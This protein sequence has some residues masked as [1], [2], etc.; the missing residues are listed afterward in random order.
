MKSEIQ[1]TLVLGL[2]A[3]FRPDPDSWGG[4]AAD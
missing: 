4:E 1:S 3:G 2:T